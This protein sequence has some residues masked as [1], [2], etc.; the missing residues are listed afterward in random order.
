MCRAF[1]CVVLIHA[2]IVLNQ[3]RHQ[4]KDKT[5]IHTID[6]RRKTFPGLKKPLSIKRVVIY[7]K[8]ALEKKNIFQR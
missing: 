2:E 3:D 8:P 7:L 6:K 1:E 4:T 5:Y